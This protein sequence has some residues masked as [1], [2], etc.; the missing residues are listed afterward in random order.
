MGVRRGG[1]GSN[2]KS[3]PLDGN[4]E[5]ALPDLEDE[6]IITHLLGVT[7]RFKRSNV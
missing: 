5:T 4:S 2:Q 3:A 7:G 6:K 1:R